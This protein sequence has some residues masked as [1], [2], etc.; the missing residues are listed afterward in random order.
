[1]DNEKLEFYTAIFERVLKQTN[2][3]QKALDYVSWLM[4]EMSYED[5]KKIAS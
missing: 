1:M 5:A 2:S 4:D 3:V